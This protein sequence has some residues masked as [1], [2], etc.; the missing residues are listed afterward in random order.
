MQQEKVYDY[1]IAVSIVGTRPLLMNRNPLPEEEAAGIPDWVE[2]ITNLDT[3]QSTTTETVGVPL[4]Q[5]DWFSDFIRS[6]Y[7]TADGQL[8]QP[9]RSIHKNMEKASL[10]YKIKGKGKKTYKDL[11][12]GA[13]A[14][15]PDQIIHKI[16]ECVPDRQYVGIGKARIVR[17]R[18]RLDNWALDFE[19][20]VFLDQLPL[21]A[22][23]K[24]LIYGGM[25]LGV[26]DYRP[27][28]GKFDV[29]RFDKMKD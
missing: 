12:M 2:N 8:Y 28:Y 1:R 24:I 4:N 22:L 6:Q 9:S 13:M 25:C 15:E 10:N 21:D 17:T 23:K 11:V 18:A 5:Q 3:K 26:G 27:H 16:Q 7:R 20:L 19:I 29:T 14:I